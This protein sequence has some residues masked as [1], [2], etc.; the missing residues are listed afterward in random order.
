MGKTAEEPFIGIQISPISFIDEGIDQVLD[1][2][3]DRVGVNVL[4]IGTISWLGLKVGRRISYKLE[5]WPDHGVPAPYAVHG[6][7]HVRVRPEY[8]ANTFI[9]DFASTNPEMAGKDILDL[10]I[11]AAR[12]RGMKVIPEFMEPLFKYGGHG[13][14][15]EVGIPNLPQCLEIDLFGRRA[16]EPCTS[17][18]DY[19]HWWHGIIEEHCR[20]YDIDG[21]MW[22]NE[23]SSPLDRMMQGQAPGCFCTQC[24][25]E[26]QDRGIDA[27]RVRLAFREAWDFFR[28]AR[29]GKSFADGALIEFFRVLLRNPEVLLWERHW[30]ERNKDL[31]REL[32]GIA[33][34]CNPS[35][36]FGLN[37]WNRNHF[38]PIRRAQWGWEEQTEYC[39]WVKP[40][41]YQHQAGEIYRKEMDYFA[42]TI[43]RDFAPEEFSPVMYRILGLNEAPLAEVVQKGMD[44]DTYVFGQCADAVR[45]V[46]GKAEVYMG[47][48][49]DAPRVRAD[50]AACSP[51]IV[52]RSVLATYRAGGK[53][54][55]FSPNYAGMN[56]SNLDGGA[57]ALEELGLKPASRS[58]LRDVSAAAH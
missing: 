11:P 34:W 27:E 48:G 36:S 39:D 25:R 32:Y 41:T 16:V 33:K 37:V 24:R 47:I 29:A 18:P 46:N 30:L 12:A 57:H 38:N 55:V 49:V 19:R 10:V 17:N 56:L 13:S 40:I 44:P 5:G 21:I 45:G 6:G 23:R 52:Y 51:D 35:L 15:G 42:E 1:T 20:N 43:L 9:K 58:T 14:A 2:L 3:K 50:Q 8:Y 54:V 53:G 7:A 22:C 4:L 31:D 26:A 28:A